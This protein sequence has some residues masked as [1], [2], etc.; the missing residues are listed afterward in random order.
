MQ[1]AFHNNMWR[2]PYFGFR[3]IIYYYRN[4]FSKKKLFEQSTIKIGFLAEC[5]RI[6]TRS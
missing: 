4:V 3:H 1:M 6:G 5:Q 2:E